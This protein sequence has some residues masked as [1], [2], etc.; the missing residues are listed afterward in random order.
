MGAYDVLVAAI[1][2]RE[3]GGF[4]HAASLGRVTTEG[5]FQL[6]VHPKLHRR[7]D[8]AFVTYGR[9][10]ADRPVPRTDPWE[11][12]PDL[13]VE[14]VSR[15]NTADNVLNK[16]G[17]YFESGTRAVW[18]VYPVASQVYVYDSPL[19]VRVL[20]RTDELD[21]GDILPDFRLPLT[22]LF[23]QESDPE[24]SWLVTD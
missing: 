17:E 19:T 11:V 6:K 12:V 15:S 4:V 1:L 24:A 7:P 20:A 9:W 10:A 16:I 3:I 18:V 21:G 23:E 14:V 5:L 8:V 22:T 2:T 13:A